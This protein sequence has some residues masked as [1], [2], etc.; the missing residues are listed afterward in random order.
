MTGSDD[1]QET[2]L[3]APAGP[4]LAQDPSENQGRI[5][6]G[7]LS[8]K[9]TPL[10]LAIILII[11][12]IAIG[13]YNQ[14]GGDAPKADIKVGSM[15]PDFSQ[16]SFSGE[17]ITLSEQQGKVVVL[18]FW[19]S[20]CAPCEKE[21]PMLQAKAASDPDGLVVIGIDRKIDGDYPARQFAEK[22]GITYPLIADDGPGG[23]DIRGPIE[24]AYG[25]GQ[26]YPMTIFISPD[27]K[28]ASYH[29]GELSEDDLN[30]QIEKARNYQG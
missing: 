23:A 15:A 17:T 2:E 14:R 11:A 28:I 26:Y 3:N 7:R 6:Y 30:K 20:G 29:I 1:T 18:N 13:I 8:G 10:A 9:Y 5:G 12:M 16:T 4:T 19:W 21:S 27:G 25:S 24:T 22:Y